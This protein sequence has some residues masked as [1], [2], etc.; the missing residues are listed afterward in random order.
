M[1]PAD[2]LCHTH[3]LVKR[4]DEP[5]VVIATNPAGDFFIGARYRYGRS[6]LWSWSITWLYF[7]APETVVADFADGKEVD[8]FPLINTASVIYRVTYSGDGLTPANTR[9]EETTHAQ[10]VL[11]AART[12][13]TLTLR[14]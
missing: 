2:E 13:K 3:V 1:S 4:Y 7:P 10:L 5:R 9:I 12:D 8:L 11:E 6:P 14:A